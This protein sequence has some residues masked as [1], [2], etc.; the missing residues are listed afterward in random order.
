LNNYTVYNYG[1]IQSQH[2]NINSGS[3]LYNFG[4][5]TTN[6]HL[7]LNS[8]G[9]IYNHYLINVNG[10]LHI[11]GIVHGNTLGGCG[12]INVC[13]KTILNGS[14]QFGLTGQ[15][16]L[17]DIGYPIGGWDQNNGTVG[18]G[19]TYCS[20][21]ACLNGAFTSSQ[22]GNWNSASTWGTSGNVAGLSYPTIGNNATIS[23]GHQILIHTD[24][25]IDRLTVQTN[26]TLIIDSISYLELSG[27]IENNGNITINSGGALVQSDCSNPNLNSGNGSYTIKRKG[28][29]NLNSYN[30]WSSPI[31]SGSTIS[32]V[33][34]GSCPCDIFCFDSQSQSWKYDYPIGYTTLCNN[35]SVTFNS[36]DVISGGDG[37]MDSGIGY[38]ASGGGN[39]FIEKSFIGEIQNGDIS[40][41]IVTTSLGNNP[42]WDDD[43]WNLVGNP[44]PSKLSAYEFWIE[45]AVNNSKITG[46]LYFWDDH[47]QGSGFN[48]NAEYASWNLLGGISSNNS[49]HVPSDYI[50]VGQGFWVI[51]NQSDSIHFTNCMRSSKDAYFFKSLQTD[52][53]SICIEI[54][55]PSQIKNAIRVGYTS[56]STDSIDANFDAPKLSGNPNLRFSSMINQQEFAIQGIQKPKTGEIKV[57]PLMIYTSEH[58]FHTIK[59]IQRESMP[60]NSH[61]V[62]LWD[63]VLNIYHD[64]DKQAY[65]VD[66]IGDWDYTNRFKLFF[67]ISNLFSITQQWQSTEPSEPT[68]V[69]NSLTSSTITYH[70]T[71]DILFL[72]CDSPIISQYQIYNP[73]G[74]LIQVSHDNHLKNSI[75]I[76]I[77]QISNGIYFLYI[78]I[79]GEKPWMKTFVK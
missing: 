41:S 26:G 2:I 72:D 37:I 78:P 58:G 17:C 12:K 69:S 45:N 76:D 16:D 31:V 40:V 48:Q 67:S 27:S 47:N 10:N 62:I 15:L 71:N 43:D 52:K 56:T 44:Y 46:G 50:A 34:T 5:I 13:G 14:G 79:E 9:F 66:L 68:S 49:N 24:S 23:N 38:F 39:S 51:A 25:K 8:N 55:T 36:N 74:N 33:F 1:S 75:Q 32:S 54:S 42:N 77:S 59:Q 21:S 53:H 60:S 29:T 18:T 6:Q 3:E 30:I 11:N 20:Q 61:H 22:S 64:I 70:Q 28:T 73:V 65:T 4:T 19:V 35:N 7:N 63:S 57:I